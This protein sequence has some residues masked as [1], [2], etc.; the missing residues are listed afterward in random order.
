MGRALSKIFIVDDHPIFR[1]GL[2]VLINQEKDMVVVGE[3]QDAPEAMQKI[4]KTRPDLVTVDISLDGISGLN[5][6]KNILAE[7]PPM[8][9][10]VLSMNDESIYAERT[11]KAGARGYLT[12]RE[13]IKNV[14]IAIRTVLN[15]GIY[16]SDKWRESLVLNLTRGD[17]RATRRLSNRELEV[18]QL[19]GQ[20]YSTQKIADELHVSS[21]TVESH[22]ANI[23]AKLDLKNSH[24]LIQYAVKMSLAGQ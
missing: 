15:G 19:T 23:K 4:S 24:E 14:S 8:L 1:Q 10:L 22:N 17:V 6:I 3:A 16:V 5:L 2:A 7:Y 21:K 20:A 9:I 11:L 13:T 18:L 12:K